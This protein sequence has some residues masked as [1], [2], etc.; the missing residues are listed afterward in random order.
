MVA[1]TKEINPQNVNKNEY[2]EAIG[3]T[4][5]EVEEY[6]F[7]RI[8]DFVGLNGKPKDKPFYFTEKAMSL[9]KKEEIML[10]AIKSMDWKRE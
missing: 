10:D 4:V 7:N 8:S 6:I 3:S 5:N 2:V 9:D 1:D